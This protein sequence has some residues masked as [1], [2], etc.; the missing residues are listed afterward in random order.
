[1]GQ[2]KKGKTGKA[3]G[4]DEPSK[5][6]PSKEQTWQSAQAKKKKTGSARKKSKK[7]RSL[8]TKQQ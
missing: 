4:P 7:Q 6:L 8:Q 5:K 1:M 2:V 3:A